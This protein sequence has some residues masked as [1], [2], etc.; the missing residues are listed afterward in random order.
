M[1]SAAQAPRGRS[2]VEFD[3]FRTRRA[4]SGIGPGLLKVYFGNRRAS[5]ALHHH[6]TYIKLRSAASNRSRI[7]GHVFTSNL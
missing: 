6:A 4:H 3:S 5:T 2:R 1:G 7:G